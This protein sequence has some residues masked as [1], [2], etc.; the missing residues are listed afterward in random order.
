MAR[1]FHAVVNGS[2]VRKKTMVL[3]LMEQWMM[4]WLDQIRKVKEQNELCAAH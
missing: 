4:N 2:L 1:T 3:G